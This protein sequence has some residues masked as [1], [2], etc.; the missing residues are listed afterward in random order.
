RLSTTAPVATRSSWRNCYA[1]THD[2]GAAPGRPPAWDLDALIDQPLPWSL[3]EV[4]CRQVDE[5]E[6]VAKQVVEAA[7]VLGHRVPFDLLA[8]VTGMDEGELIGVLRTL[9]SRGV[10]VESAGF[11]G[12]AG[13]P[14]ATSDEMS[15][16][17][18]L[19]R[20]AVTSRMLGRQRRRLHEA[21][22]EAL[23]SAGDADPALVAHHAQAAGRYQEMVAA[24]RRGAALYL[25]IGSAYQALKLAEMGLAEAGDDLDL[26]A[27]A[28][29]AAWL[30]GLLEDAT[31]YAQRWR[32]LATSA[33]DRAEALFL[34]IRLAWE[35]DEA[36]EMV[37]FTREVEELIAALPS[38]ADRARAMTAVAQS[39]LLQDDFDTAVSWADRALA[40]A[41]QPDAGSPRPLGQAGGGVPVRLAALVERGSARIE[42]PERAAE[43]HAL[44]A[45]VVDEAEKHGAWVLAA[46]ALNH[47]V[48]APLPEASLT[49]QA[50][51]LERMRV[52]AERA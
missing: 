29:Q 24:A 45:G 52:D 12:P 27:S 51:T 9:V 20:E 36:A 26:L 28:A 38:G 40:L 10:L 5:L 31:G 37:R 21:A 33:T 44:L 8:A 34:L 30:A 25:S 4:L 49:E 23:L 35:A 15:F 13:P 41:D 6:P 19:V 48:Q 42:Q 18:A 43:G 7:A 46:R 50:E 2:G 22:L 47:L 3:A 39:A 16:R 17:H 32:D 14:A 1:P 11:D